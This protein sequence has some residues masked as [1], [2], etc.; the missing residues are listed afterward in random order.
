M[1]PVL[2]TELTLFRYF[3]MRQVEVRSFREDIS[4]RN[5]RMFMND[6]REVNRI[7]AERHITGG[8]PPPTQDVDP[9]QGVHQ[10]RATWWDPA[11]LSAQ[12]GLGQIQNCLNFM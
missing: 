7:N 5:R 1:E 12:R 11:L 10:S 3:S 9:R 8:G 2:K 4:E 6:R